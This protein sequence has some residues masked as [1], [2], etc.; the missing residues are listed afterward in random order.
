M[1]KWSIERG[2][3]SS[4]LENLIAKQRILSSDAARGV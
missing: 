2:Y 1:G 3:K 4:A